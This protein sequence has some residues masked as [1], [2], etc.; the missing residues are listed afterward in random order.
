MVVVQRHILLL[1][2]E[3]IRSINKKRNKKK[4]FC[5]TELIFFNMTAI[6]WEEKE[7]F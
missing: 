1:V 3:F 2:L 4:S 5:L 7:L 6:N